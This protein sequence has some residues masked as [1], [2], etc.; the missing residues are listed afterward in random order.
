MLSL[1]VH[2]CFL[3]SL[4]FHFDIQLRHQAL[5]L[6]VCE[7]EVW[8]IS[9]LV[10]LICFVLNNLMLYSL[11][12]NGIFII[13][14]NLVFTPCGMCYYVYSFSYC[15]H[16]FLILNIYNLLF[17]HLPFRIYLLFCYSSRFTPV[18]YIVNL[19]MGVWHVSYSVFFEIWNSF[20]SRIKFL[21]LK[22][23]LYKS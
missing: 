12:W 14:Y 21:S 23:I 10:V 18:R 5:F 1:E 19:K 2:L 13:G 20:N 11:F 3:K 16:R 6:C 9:F 17:C 15:Y 8:Y 22:L 7:L 4:W